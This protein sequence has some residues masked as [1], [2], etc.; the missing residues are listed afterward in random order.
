MKFALIWLAFCSALPVASAQAADA[1]TVTIVDGRVRLLRDTTWYKVVS[2]A[3]VRQG[4]IIEAID[5]A[6]VQVELRAG[7]TF[8]LGGPATL[9]AAS[10]PIAGEKLA[11]PIDLDLANGWLKLVAK[12][13]TTGVRVRFSGAVL[14]TTDAVIVIHGTTEASEFFMESGVAKVALLDAG[15]RAGPVLDAVAGE[16]RGRSGDWP[17][18]VEPHPPRPFVAAMPRPMQDALPSLAKRY[19]A[20]PTLVAEREIDYAEAEPWL[21]GPYRRTFL[22]QFAPRLRDREFRAAVDARIARYPEWD[23]ILHPDKYLPKVP[24]ETK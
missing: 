11:G 5:A 3:R 7:G 16:Y 17:F 19:K 21:A 23:R 22:K 15:G 13:P 20:A 8:Y 24:A 1:G 9:Y 14:D 6:D 12:A 2:G 18:R 4:D 10:L